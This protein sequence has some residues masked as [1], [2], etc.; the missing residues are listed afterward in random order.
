M[1]LVPLREEVFSTT[2]LLQPFLRHTDADVQQIPD[3]LIHVL[4]VKPDLRE[5]GRLDF[6]ERCLAELRHAP[7]YLRLFT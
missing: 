4:P 6:Y 1:I 7:S 5:F 2:H 3:D